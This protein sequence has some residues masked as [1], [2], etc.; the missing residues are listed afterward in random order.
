MVL[1]KKIKIYFLGSGKIGIPTLNAVNKNENFELVGIGTQEDRTGG[2][3]NKI[4]STP[5]AVWAEE[6]KLKVDKIKSVNNEDF[7]L[8]LDSLKI[9]ILLVASFGQLLKT[10]LL[11]LPSVD[12]VNIHAS[13][14]PK[15]RGASPLTAAILSGDEKTGIAFMKMEKGLDTGSVY[16]MHEYNMN[17]TENAEELEDILGE[18][19]GNNAVDVLKKIALKEVEPAEQN[20]EEATHVWKIKKQNG[21]INW[22]DSAEKIERM[23]RAYMPWP[24]AFFFLK[25]GKKQKKIQITSAKVVSKLDEISGTIIKADKNEWIVA[26][27]E[28]ALEIEGLIPEGK[29]EM[30]GVE[31]L[32]GCRVEEGKS[33]I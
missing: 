21:L 25:S 3:K 12:C 31:F 18:I 10:K 23:V 20:H 24:G 6:N 22:K 33:V 14:L 32:R 9:D 19:A 17:F 28:D 1:N 7:L 26:C 4:I 15:Y 5:V 16:Y 8:Y 2:R 27:G 11:S 13:L 29:N 30:S